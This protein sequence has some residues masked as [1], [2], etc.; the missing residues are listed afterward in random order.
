M[1]YTPKTMEI[2]KALAYGESAEL[3]AA[4][5]DITVDEVNQIAGEY[6]SDIVECQVALKE[7]G[8]IE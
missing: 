4:V 7:A 2:I 3:I 6:A 1:E 5:E 8:Y